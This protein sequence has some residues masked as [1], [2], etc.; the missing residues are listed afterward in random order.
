MKL[1]CKL[2]FLVSLLLT[3][4]AHTQITNLEGKT[5]SYQELNNLFEKIRSS[6]DVPGAS[7]AIINDGAV[8]Y[9]EVYG[10]R[11]T[12][13]MVRIDTNTT[14]E[15]A[16]LTKPVFAYGFA[17]LVAAGRI[18][19]DTPL[20]RYFSYEDIDYDER[21]KAVT[22]RMILSHTAGFPNWRNNSKDG[23]LYFISNPGEKFFYSGEGYV[24]LGKVLQKIT[25]ITLDQYYRDSVFTP[26]GMEHTFFIWNAHAD[27]VT[28]FGHTK[29]GKPL[30][31]TH[32]GE[33]RIASGLQ[34]NASDY[35]R[36]VCGLLNAD[37]TLKAVLEDFFQPAVKVKEAGV[38]ADYWGYGFA[39]EMRGEKKMI[40]HFG[41]NPGFE[42]FMELDPVSRYGFVVFTNAND[43]LKL[44]RKVN[45]D[46]LHKK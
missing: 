11:S 14:F 4:R 26:L 36:F 23:K 38:V 18:A 13:S 43:G 3:E 35:S 5:F 40:N 17:K 45:D 44:V 28:S 42:S 12:A 9:N 6:Y 24:Y 15:A 2:I 22:A 16:S 31:K 34:T 19:M 32:P 37:N 33:V 20:N 41:A 46:I 10:V 30:P 21:A 8:V 7:I 25:G 39:I 27:S 29:K 1:F